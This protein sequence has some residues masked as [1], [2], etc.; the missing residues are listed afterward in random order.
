MSSE[1]YLGSCLV[2]PPLGIEPRTYAL[3][4]RC[5]T[6]ELKGRAFTVLYLLCSTRSY[7]RQYILRLLRLALWFSALAAFP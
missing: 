1:N 4:V 7:Y 3:Q 6:T 5:S 2:E